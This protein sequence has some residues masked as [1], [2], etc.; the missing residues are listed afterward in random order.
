MQVKQELFKSLTFYNASLWAARMNDYFAVL[1]LLKRSNQL[2]KTMII[3]LDPHSVDEFD[4]DPRWIPL[5]AEATVA[6]V[7]SAIAFDS[8]N[9]GT[10][11]W[12]IASN[13]ADTASALLARFS[14]H[15][16]WA[17]IR[18][19]VKFIRE[20]QCLDRYEPGTRISESLEPAKHLLKLPD[21]SVMYQEELRSRSRQYLR[22]TGREQA[23]ILLK[24][25]HSISTRKIR[26]LWILIHRMRALSIEP[27]IWLAPF[28]PNEYGMIEASPRGQFIVELEALLRNEA[29]LR[30]FKVVG[31]YNPQRI[32][33]VEEEFIDWWHPDPVC[34]ARAFSA[35]AKDAL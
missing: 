30:G 10:A 21:G 8:V 27:V 17:S 22:E 26:Q 19:T 2:P 4:D 25:K 34:V 31:S 7:K 14:T 1:H 35:S 28:G 18:Q 11:M 3:G 6:L 13:V 5:S 24:T 16:S 9:R 12:A 33:C 20:C 15:I 23:E 32:P 29:R